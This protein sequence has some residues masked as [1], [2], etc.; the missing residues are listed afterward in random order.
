MN[1]EQKTDSSVTNPNSQFLLYQSSDG[2]TKVQVKMMGETVWLTQKQMAELFQT[3]KQNI[4]LHIQNIFS[5]GELEENSVIKEFLTTAIDGKRYKTQY[6]NLDMIISVGYRVNSI[7][8]TQF[9]IWA[10]KRLREYII[11][12][13]ALDDERLEDPERNDYYHE[14]IERVRK[15]RTSERNFYQKITDLYATSIDYD[16]K[17][18][19]TRN[20]FA[21]VQNKMHYGIHGHTAAEIIAERASA[22]KPNMGI[23]SI[24]IEN[25]RK[26]DVFIAKNYLTEKE[27]RQLDLIVDQYLSFAELR[28]LNQKTMTMEE[29]IRKLDD[30]LRFNEKE[31]LKHHGKISKEQ[32]DEK[33]ESEFKKFTIEQGSV[34]QSDFDR[35]IKNIAKITTPPT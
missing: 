4:S 5:E 10:T 6:Y 34:I 16:S 7:R 31:I 25:I 29:W 19:L 3:T 21:T 12:G 23:T 35:E 20:F 14:L 32:A 1:N 18:S 8:G 9:R 22:N 30:F 24:Q 27:L 28:A 17:N 15:I 11:K 26:S 33:A 2:Q 13:F